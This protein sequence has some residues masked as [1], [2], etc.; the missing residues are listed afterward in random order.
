MDAKLESHR[1]PPQWRSLSRQD[2]EDLKLLV[3]ADG[4]SRGV[5][6]E[7]DLAT[8]QEIP[9]AALEVRQ[10]LLNLLLNAIRAS[11]SGVTVQLNTAI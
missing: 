11:S 2:L 6:I 4:R 5:S 1:V 3:E 10:I 7:A 9:L 8:P